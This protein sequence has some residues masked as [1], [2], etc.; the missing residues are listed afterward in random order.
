MHHGV[1]KAGLGETV[2]QDFARPSHPLP[3]PAGIYRGIGLQANSAPGELGD[4]T[5]DIPS[6]LIYMR[7]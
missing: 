7:E 3:P 5:R 6:V 1:V 4:D 2:F